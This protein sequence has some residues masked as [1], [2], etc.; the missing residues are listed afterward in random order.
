MTF[1]QEQ[2]T[3]AGISVAGR[4]ALNSATAERGGASGGGASFQFGRNGGMP[5]AAADGGD[6]EIGLKHLKA[7]G[8]THYANTP[9]YSNVAFQ[10]CCPPPCCHDLCA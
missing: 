7:L 4:F 6:V 8:G 5:G 10:A 9:T 3:R 1:R 2:V